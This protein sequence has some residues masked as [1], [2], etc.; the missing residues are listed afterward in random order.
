MRKD[1]TIWDEMIR[2]QT[3]DLLTRQLTAAA[4]VWE[5]MLGSSRNVVGADFVMFDESCGQIAVLMDGCCARIVERVHDLGGTADWPLQDMGGQR[6]RAADAPV[7]AT[8]SRFSA[9]ALD[10]VS[11]S[12]LSAITLAEARGDGATA[13][14]LEQ[15]WRDIDRYLWQALPPP[16]APR[17]ALVMWHRV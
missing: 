5:R 13:E 16:V 8:Q 14:L 2:L 15:L 10:A 6:P 4:E 1:Q 17:R 9:K 11:K 7:E 3:L 12:L